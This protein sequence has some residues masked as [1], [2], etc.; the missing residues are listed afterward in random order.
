MFIEHRWLY[1][2]SGPVP[3]EMF[4]VPLGKARVL[5]EGTDV[6]F[7]STS[8]MTLEAHRAAEILASHGVSAEIVD[9]RSLRPLDE[10]T[11]L[12]AVSEIDR[13]SPGRIDVRA[14][15]AERPRFSG[16]ALIAIGLWLS[17]G[18]LKLGV[19]YFRTFP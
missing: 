10:D 3:E 15:S 2:I 7:V 11:I 4:R 13:L 19:G 18:L 14:Y 6:T 5:R 17:A 12:K 16:F 9:V 8:Y 1:N